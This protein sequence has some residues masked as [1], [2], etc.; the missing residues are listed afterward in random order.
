MSETTHVFWVK[1]DAELI[2]AWEDAL[3]AID[4]DGNKIEAENKASLV[5]DAE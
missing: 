2:A 5:G 3:A 1:N 4:P